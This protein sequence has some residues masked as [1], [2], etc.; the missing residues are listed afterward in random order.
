MP[1]LRIG[2]LVGVLLFPPAAA[3]DPSGV[4]AIDLAWD[5]PASCPVSD[6]IQRDVRRFLGDASLGAT[7]PPVSARVVVEEGVDQ[8]FEVRMVTT[9]GGETRERALSTATCEEARELVAFLLALLVDPNARHAPA[10]KE[11]PP[12]VAAPPPPKPAPARAPPPPPA[13]QTEP[14]F[15]VGLAGKAELGMLPGGSLGGELRT[16]FLFSGFSLEAFG[17]A[18]LPRNVQS[19]DVP[20]AGGTFSAFEAGLLACL[21][22]APWEGPSLHACAGPAL[23]L[24]RG[25][26]TGVDVPES[27][28]ALFGSASVEAALVIALSSKLSLRP[29]VGLLVPFRRPVF[30]IHEVGTIHQPSVVT[31]RAGLGLEARF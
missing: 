13:E 20:G 3:A 24:L 8:R 19:P 7:L 31:V 1:T 29:M 27:A 12:P 4:P 16:G 22:G 11:P 6:D 17:T 28:E 26:G 25:K 15:V 2:A 23:V 18:W 5:G 30:A 21:R 10:E 14:W 9:S